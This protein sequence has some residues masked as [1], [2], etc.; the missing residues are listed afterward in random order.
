MDA[1]PGETIT[2]VVD[3]GESGAPLAIRIRNAADVDVVARTTVGVAESPAGSGI[4]R[5]SLTAPATDGGY[6]VLWDDGVVYAAE[7]LRVSTTE[8][9][10]VSAIADDVEAIRQRIGSSIVST[11]PVAAGG[12]VNIVQGDD[13]LDEDGRALVWTSD[14]WPDLSSGTV[15]LRVGRAPSLDKTG[16][17]VDAEEVSVD[18]THAETAALFKG[19][20]PYKLVLTAG[21]LDVATLASG[22]FFVG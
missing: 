7:E 12:E 16:T 18:L 5:K 15:K 19:M 9:G 17:V 3:W 4:Y 22:R 11:A 2:P 6:M 8:A 10:D 1:S 14:T 13:Y 20:Y 21:D